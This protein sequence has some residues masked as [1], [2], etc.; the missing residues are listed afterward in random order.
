M[1]WGCPTLPA[2]T[3]G[4]RSEFYCAVPSALYSAAQTKFQTRPLARR[5]FEIAVLHVWFQRRQEDPHTRH[6]ARC[7]A[8][9]RESRGEERPVRLVT[10]E[11][12]GASRT[13]K[14]LARLNR[15]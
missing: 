7:A 6:H 12:A 11:A 9:C 2:T 3:S 15:H 1:I 13:I 4:I 10:Q 14:R 5:T 8:I